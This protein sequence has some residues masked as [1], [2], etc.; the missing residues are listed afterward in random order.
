MLSK[1]NVNKRNRK[2]LNDCFLEIT[3]ILLINL[4]KSK[5]FLLKVV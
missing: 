5:T 3:S 4:L 2:T 1:T